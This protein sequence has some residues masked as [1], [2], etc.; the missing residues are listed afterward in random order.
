MKPF[1]VFRQGAMWYFILN[2]TQ[3]EGYDT[4]DAA[5]VAAQQ[6]V[7]N[8]RKLQSHKAREEKKAQKEE[9]PP[10]G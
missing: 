9:K 4:K 5:E 10:L 2:G 7:V 3:S 8:A 6:A 1:N